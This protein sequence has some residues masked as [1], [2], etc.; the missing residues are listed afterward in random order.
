MSRSPL[1]LALAAGVMWCALFSSTAMALTLDEA[2]SAAAASSPSLKLAHEQVVQ[3]EA[4]RAQA[5]ALVSPKLVGEAS[6]TINDKEIALN[7]ADMIPED[8]AAFID[9]STME[10]IVIQQKEAFGANASVIQPL[11]NAQS[12]PLLRAAYANV[13]SAR[14]QEQRASQQIRAGAA[15]AWYGAAVASGMVDLA[16]KAVAQA[17]AHLAR[18]TEMVRLGMLPER[19]S[20]QAELD[21]AR[22]R[23]DR[24]AATLGLDTALQALRALT[25]LDDVGELVLPEQTVP[26]PDSL[27][28]AQERSVGHRLDL[29]AAAAD[30]RAAELQTN[31]YR[32]D[33]L[34]TVDARFTY[35][36]SENTG[37]SD[38]KTFWMLVFKANWLLWDGGARVGKSRVAASQARQAAIVEDQAQQTATD[39][40]SLAWQRLDHARAA[41]TSAERE[42]ALA[43]EN[44]RLAEIA[45]QNGG[46]T[47]L[48]L[49][50]ARLG[51]LASEMNR[52]QERANR[53]LA[54]IDVR[55]AIGDF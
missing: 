18:T 27:A 9:T 42:C 40:L 5:F 31:A 54:A 17:E 47:T 30:R 53:D 36:Y 49:N 51:A 25:G 23:R 22:A 39:E 44:L 13:D 55:V 41:L 37:F 2:M 19:A 24:E 33:W 7:F 52:L 4:W 1:T 45:Y 29:S 35:A 11:F 26:V 8:L 21:L 6:Y 48:E 15:K 38:D 12:L 28:E 43:A 32:L 3:A 46:A 20:L 10:P 34:P 16:G 14:A 50:D